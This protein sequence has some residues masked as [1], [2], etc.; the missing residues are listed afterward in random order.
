MECFPCFASCLFFLPCVLLLCFLSFSV[1]S[2]SPPVCT[3]ARVLT[4]LHYGEEDD[5]ILQ[6]C[7]V[8]T[9]MLHLHTTLLHLSMPSQR[10]VQQHDTPFTNTACKVFTHSLL[11]SMSLQQLFTFNTSRKLTLLSATT[12]NIWVFPWNVLLARELIH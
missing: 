3:P 1:L 8:I 9:C 4:Q 2:P 10:C 11:R 7:H 6:F 5:S 12:T